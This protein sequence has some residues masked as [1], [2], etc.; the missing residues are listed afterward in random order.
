LEL[1]ESQALD[2]IAKA[3]AKSAFPVMI[4]LLETLRM[5][6]APRFATG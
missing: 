5:N 2:A 6:F 4:N 1:D 3:E